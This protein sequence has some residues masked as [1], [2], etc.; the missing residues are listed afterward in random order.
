MLNII[1]FL[2]L[3]FP[4]M[5]F[6]E[7]KVDPSANINAVRLEN[8]LIWKLT[9]ELELT[10]KEEIAFSNL[11]KSIGFERR[12]LQS[13]S[14]DLSLKLKSNAS[15]LTDYKKNLEKLAANNLKEVSE[16]ELL[17]GKEKT[18]KYVF[19]KSEI[20]K[21]ITSELSKKTELGKGSSS[22]K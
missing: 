2:V 7:N 9:D 13:E 10:A 20:L 18:A 15:L 6:A 4:W 8:L 14:E 16:I 22:I 5:G 11:V 19:L 3:A 12:L 21:R 17:L 1:L